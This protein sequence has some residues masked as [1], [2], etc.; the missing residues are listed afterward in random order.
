MAGFAIHAGHGVVPGG[1][2][3]RRTIDRGIDLPRGQADGRVATRTEV[4][5]LAFGRLACFAQQRPIDGLIPGLGH[6]RGAP[7]LVD[8]RMAGTT[9]LGIIE[10]LGAQQ[11]VV[12]RIGPMGKEGQS[13]LFLHQP[14]TRRFQPL[15]IVLGGFGDHRLGRQQN[16][17][18]DAEHPEDPGAW[19]RGG[20]WIR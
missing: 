8:L 13:V 3:H 10:I 6:H 14:G 19:T 5:D 20:R 12:R 7:L 9:D 18:G 11:D 2:L 16:D 1:E 17:Q 4:V 15:V